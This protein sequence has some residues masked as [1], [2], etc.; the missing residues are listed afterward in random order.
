MKLDS[1]FN[2][3]KTKIQK[4]LNLTPFLDV[5]TVLLVFLIVSFSPEESKIQTSAEIILPESAH[6][7]KSVP[8]VKVEIT[9]QMI[10]VNNQVVEGLSPV[11]ADAASWEKFKER[12]LPYENEKKGPVLLVA[13]RNTS[14]RSVDRAAAFLAAS[15][16]GELYLLT[17]FKEMPK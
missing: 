3:K 4:F 11:T 13:D 17:D 14:Y 6:T 1:K 2:L 7:L 8:N 10:K 5:M 9:D 16:F 12:L 15:G